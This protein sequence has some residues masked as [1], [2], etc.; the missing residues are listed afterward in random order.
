MLFNKAINSRK[1]GQD[2]YKSIPT[3][4]LPQCHEM[5]PPMCIFC[6]MHKYQLEIHYPFISQS[7]D[8]GCFRVLQ[9]E[10]LNILLRLH[11]AN[12]CFEVNIF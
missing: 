10:L 6:L 12:N 11:R 4:S 5:K 1:T 9:L 3:V 8:R 7:G 2:F